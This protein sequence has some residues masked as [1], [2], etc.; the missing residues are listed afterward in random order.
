M[1]L[2]SRKA[3]F[4]IRD[5]QSPWHGKNLYDLYEEAHTPWEWHAALF[6]YARELGLI[7]F[8]APFDATAVDFLTQLHVPLFKIASFENGDIP[9][10]RRVA[11]SGKP[12]IIS[13]GTATLEEIAQALDAARDAGAHELILLKCTSS[14]PAPHSEANLRAM[15]SLSQMFRVPVGLSDHTQGITTSI[16]AVAL[17]AVMLEKHVTLR[18]AEGGVDAAFSLEPEELA[19]LVQGARQAWESLGSADYAPTA[20]ETASRIFRRSLYVVKPIRSGEAFTHENLR[21]IRPGHGLPPA[22]LEAIIG[23]GYAACDL[24][25]ETALSREH[26]E[27]R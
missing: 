21:I 17:G 12:M 27:W 25:P 24:A 13:T 18:R 22:E 20:S 5:P 8:S 23:R 4:L 1:T 10:I 19:A 11:A 15:A 14:Y 26:I 9:L 3:D 6:S 2:R 7:A 16:A